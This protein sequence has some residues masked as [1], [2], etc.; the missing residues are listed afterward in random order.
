MLSN[1]LETT[2]RGKR[3]RFE[4]KARRKDG[5]VFTADMALSAL[6]DGGEYSVLWSL[7]DITRQKEAEEKLREAYE[8]EK[9]L[10]DL[11]MRFVSMI[12]HEFRSP[13]SVIQVQADYLRKYSYR[14]QEAQKIER[15]EEIKAQIQRLNDML[16]D[17]LLLSQAE[18]VGLDVHPTDIDVAEFCEGVLKHIRELWPR[19]QIE[20]TASGDCT[21]PALDAKLLHQIVSNLLSNALKYSPGGSTVH[22]RLTGEP[23]QIVLQI[24]DAGIGIPE[25]DQQRLFENFHRASNVGEISGTGLGLSIVKRAVEA[26]GGSIEFVSTLGTGTTFTVRLPI[27]GGGNL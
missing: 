14:L 26:H 20:Y 8:R 24:A 16:N 12:S 27:P 21:H 9:Q 4:I 11:K 3:M 22:V 10:S 18:T 7:R 25:A 23:Q 2:A 17:T 6:E 15:L 5:S 1:A 19:H 13:M